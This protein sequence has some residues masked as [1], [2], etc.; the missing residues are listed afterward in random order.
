MGLIEY[1]LN[2]KITLLS[3]HYYK[4]ISNRFVKISIY[5]DIYFSGLIIIFYK[6]KHFVIKQMLQDTFFKIFCK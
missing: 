1:P 3:N 6:F 2:L 5:E 4:P